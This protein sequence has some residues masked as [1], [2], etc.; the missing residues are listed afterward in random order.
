MELPEELKILDEKLIR[1]FD[2][3]SE[4][5][6]DY[7]DIRAE[8]K[9]GSSVE[10]TDM[11][12]K[13]I[14]SFETSKCGIRTFYNGGWGFVVLEDLTRN[15]LEQNFKKA[16][17]LARLSESFNK[18]KFR[19]QEKKP[20]QEN[21]N[22]ETKEPIETSDISE[23]IEVVKNQEKIANNYS[24]YIKNTH[25]LY[26]DASGTSL[27]IDS[28]GSRVT[29]KLSILRMFSAIFAQKNGIIQRGS[30]SVGGLGG[31][32]ILKTSKAENLSK[33]S[34][35]NAVELLEAESPLGGKFTLIMDPSLTGTFIHEA[36]GHACE[37]DLV[38]NK[39]S[40]LEGKIGVQ[41]AGENV[42]V[43]DD[44]RLGIGKDFGLPY[45]LYGTYFIDDEGIPSQKTTIIEKGIFKNYLHNLETASRMNQAPNGHGR[46]SSSTSKPQVR[47]G[48]TKLEPG[49]WSLDEM[50]ADTKIGIL[51]EDFTYGYTDP[52]TGNFQFKAKLSYKI[53][54]GEKKELMRDVALSGMTLEVLNRINAI[55]KELKFSDGNCGKGGQSVRVSDGGPYIR[56]K[57]IVVGGL[58]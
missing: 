33:K 8:L 31:L 32:E 3:L 50:I 58:Q 13:E 46:A 47:M 30:N 18:T 34:A 20:L 6:I 55:G 12:S 14:S 2:Q 25:T 36:F 44:P 48:V 19:I 24:E 15:V 54:N 21:F 42:T 16:V 56:V 49:D 43:I 52:T 11:K 22:L 5:K 29:Q 9:L 7:W 40:I 35:K 1:K 23:K 28:F 27:Y 41:V 53:E 57:D 26:F 4:N 38:L 17:K 37:A 10:F 39:E 51:C 45:E